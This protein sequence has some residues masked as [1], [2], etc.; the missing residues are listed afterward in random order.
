MSTGGLGISDA[1]PSD[2]ATRKLTTEVDLKELGC[3]DEVQTSESSAREFIYLVD[4]YTEN[5]Q[6]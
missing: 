2:F 6:L 3:Q 1:E 4:L 5:T